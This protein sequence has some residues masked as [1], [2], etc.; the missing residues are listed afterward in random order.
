MVDYTSWEPWY[1]KIRA[2][3]GYSLEKDEE[4]SRVLD[5]LLGE[6]DVEA[7][8]KHLRALLSDRTAVV[9]GAGPNLDGH[10]EALM[11]SAEELSG[12]ALVAADGATSGLME[13]GL[14]PDVIATDLDGDMHD[15]LEAH[16]HGS[17]IV[18]HAHGDNIEALKE[19][20]PF[21]RSGLTVGT[22]QT[23][24]V[25]KIRNFGGFTDGDR[26]VFLVLHFGA[27]RA[28]LAGWSF[29]GMVGRHSKPWL[30]KAMEAGPVK[31]KKL[32]FARELISWL[33]CLHPGRI[34]VLEEDIPDTTRLEVADLPSFLQGAGD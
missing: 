25:G 9:F 20:V 11:G 8:L 13:H 14:V 6:H 18:V 32:S 27:S 10:I 3:F 17:V 34:F 21:F 23:K 12:L 26:A 22:C 19:H 15:I 2:A 4:A 33:A 7:A 28:L 1:E 24:P 31:R 5:E 29:G 30:K 16:G